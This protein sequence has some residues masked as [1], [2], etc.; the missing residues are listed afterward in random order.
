M[1]HP[2]L[3]LNCALL[4][5]GLLLAAAPA[6]RAQDDPGMSMF[7]SYNQMAVNMSL[8]DVNNAA[9]M[10]ASRNATAGK[11]AAAPA[12]TAT[13]TSFAYAPTAALQKQTAA[14]YVA[15]VRAANP[16]AAQT[17]AEALAGKTNYPALYRELNSGTGLREN[18]AADVMA[19]FLLENWIV[20][21]GMTDASVITA[22]RTQAVRAQAA[23]IMARNPKLS[24]GATLAQFGEQL[25]LNTAML[26]VGRLRAQHD[27]NSATYSRKVA[28]QFQRQ[29]HFSMTQLQLTG[30]GLVKK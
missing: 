23:G 6:A 16:A 13:R 20:A 10:A 14:A 17:V 19:L 8:V 5:A 4:A 2:L 29:Y 15:Q 9:V 24:S 28:T 3:P 27:G 25:K 7:N 12:R 1:R 18:D 22:A 21:N 30:Q 26:E 11:G